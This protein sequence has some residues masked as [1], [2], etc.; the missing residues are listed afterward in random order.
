MSS[1]SAF[2]RDYQH[3]QYEVPE[4][5]SHY[6]EWVKDGR[7]MIMTRLNGFE[8][9]TFAVKCA[10]RGNNVYRSRTRRRFEGLSSM[11]EDLVFFNPRDRGPKETRALWV[12]LTYDSKLCSFR[13]AWIKIGM[14]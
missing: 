9:E 8:N 5:I 6:Q 7:Y 4:I 2:R 10:K 14:S 11:A 13:E 12:T 1:L 3:R